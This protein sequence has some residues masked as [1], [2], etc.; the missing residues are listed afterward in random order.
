MND[1]P[2]CLKALCILLPPLI[3]FDAL[4]RLVLALL[5]RRLLL[6]ARPRHLGQ[7]GVDLRLVGLAGGF[8]KLYDAC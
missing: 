2:W 8:L 6:L 7:L 5:R 1:P 4:E 3:F